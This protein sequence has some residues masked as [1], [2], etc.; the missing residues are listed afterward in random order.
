MESCNTYN[1]FINS[2]STLLQ[3]HNRSV[4]TRPID[5][6]KYRPCFGW[7]PDEVIRQTFEKTTQFYPSSPPNHL[8]KR[9]KSPY[10]ACNIP[11]REEPL[12]T[13]TVH[14]DTPAVDD[15]SKVAQLFVGT[16]SLVCDVYGMK[17]EKQFINTLQDIIR[18]RGAPTK[19]VSDNAQVEISNKVKDILS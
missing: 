17:T 1:Y 13:D 5:C 18:Q 3:N 8:R 10:P 9:F 16:K 12:A 4:K 2:V 15:G 7:L 6:D 11:R 14:S 19:L